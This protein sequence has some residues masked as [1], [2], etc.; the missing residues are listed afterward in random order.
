MCQRLSEVLESMLNANFAGDVQ[1]PTQPEKGIDGK[2]HES[3]YGGLSLQLQRGI[4]RGPGFIQ[5]REEIADTG[6]HQ[7]W[8][9]F[10]VNRGSRLQHRRINFVVDL[11]HRAVE[12]LPGVAWTAARPRRATGHHRRKSRHNQAA[13]NGPP[14]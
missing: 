1:Y 10:G 9:H 8:G 7:R 11:C 13:R 12:A 2:P 6:S 3:L 4:Q 5:V 14:D